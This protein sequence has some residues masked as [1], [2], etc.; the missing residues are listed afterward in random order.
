MSAKSWVWR[1]VTCSLL[2]M[3]VATMEV[4]R[5]AR[6]QTPNPVGKTAP[7]GAI[8]MAHPDE[9]KV[10]AK[11]LRAALENAFEGLEIWRL[12]AFRV[13]PLPWPKDISE[14]VKPYFPPGTSFDEAE[15][16]LQQAGFTIIRPRQTKPLPT[17]DI[18]GYSVV[19][20]LVLPIE[21]PPGRSV[22]RLVLE[23]SNT[24]NYGKVAG[25][26]CRAYRETP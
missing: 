19:G 9:I 4:D 25:V 18:T 8:E 7:T 22:A 5:P 10:K 3:G 21:N 13:A 11:E 24:M 12:N 14:V 1:E 6:A 2:F 17:P 20:E 15:A 16:I 23:A 26:W